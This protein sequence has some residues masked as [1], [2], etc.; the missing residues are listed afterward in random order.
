M[1]NSNCFGHGVD[2]EG[3]QRNVQNCECK[4]IYESLFCSVHN[5]P[6]ETYVI[7]GGI[8]NEEDEI[9]DTTPQVRQTCPACEEPVT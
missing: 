3:R 4:L 9:W 8:W 6:L 1:D 7:S 2:S 5:R